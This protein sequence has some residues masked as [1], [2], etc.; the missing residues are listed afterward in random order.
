MKRI[1]YKKFASEIIKTMEEWLNDRLLQGKDYQRQAL[2]EDENFNDEE[3]KEE[4]NENSP[5]KENKQGIY[6]LF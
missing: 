5:N 1:Y 2:E 6:L 3:D 4:E